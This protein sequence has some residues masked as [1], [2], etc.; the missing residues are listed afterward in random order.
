MSSSTNHTHFGFESVPLDEKQGRVN[1]VFHKVAQ[2]YDLMNDLMS[3]G[4]HR[5]WKEALVTKIRPPKHQPFHSLDVAGGTGD[6]AFRIINAGGEHTHVSVCDINTDMLNVGR[7]RAQKH[8]ET[9]VSFK[10][11]NAENLPFGDNHFDA[12]S[13]AFG[14]RN[15]PRISLALSEA[16][17]VLKYGSIFTCLEFSHV[18]VA[19]LDAF[20][21]AYSF[22]II[23][24]MGRIV[25]GDAQPYQYLV[26]SIRQFPKPKTF[27]KMIKD[28]GFSQT[29]HTLLSGGI[30]ALHTGWKI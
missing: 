5:L 30:V 15:V 23:P 29:S 13:I 16:Y 26:E 27:E 6:V 7:D 3:L 2:R 28:V 17:R 20:Y 22:N 21:K 8:G 25:T 1:D 14:I 19:G 24:K 11:G 18:D 10:E 12:Y 4:M 9:R